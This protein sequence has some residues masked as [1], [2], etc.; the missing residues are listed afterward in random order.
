MKLIKIA[1]ASGLLMAG[2]ALGNAYSDGDVFGG[3]SSTLK[4]LGV[5]VT[6]TT[7]VLGSFDFDV[8]DGTDGS[9]AGIGAVF[10]PAY[11]AAVNLPN[12]GPY[13]SKVG[14]TVGSEVVVPTTFSMKFWFRDGDAAD[15]TVLVFANNIGTIIGTFSEIVFTQS[16]G[17][18]AIEG[19]INATG[20]VAY[21]VSSLLGNFTLDAAYAT[22]SSQPVPE[23][24]SLALTLGLA[25]LGLEGMRRR[26]NRA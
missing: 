4:P 9:P 17:T 18:L 5:T 14:F 16:G 19:E 13:Y 22:I 26:S 24:G 25:V 15:E 2:V 6:T 23:G 8:F 12:N 20:K 10:S 21:S 7:P 3:V 11:T 1:S